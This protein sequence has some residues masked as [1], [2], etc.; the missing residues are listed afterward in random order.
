M[1]S[2]ANLPF[3]SGQALAGEVFVGSTLTAGTTIPVNAASLVSTFTLWNPLGSGK[4]VVLYQYLL[5]LAGTTTVV[6]GYAGLFFQSGVGAGVVAPTSQT[7]LTPVNGNIGAGLASVAKL[8]SAGTLTG[9]PTILMP[10][11]SFG[12]TGGALGPAA[13]ST[14]AFNGGLVIPP[15]VLVTVAGNVAQTQPMAQTF[16]WAEVGI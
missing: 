4:N 12:T 2:I 15:G 16:I 8:L 1:T 5:A 14:F 10:M 3:G 11:I 13:P 9:T 7:A 6:I